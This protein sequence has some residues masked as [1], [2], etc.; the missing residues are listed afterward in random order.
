MNSLRF[1]N[2][3]FREVRLDDLPL[4]VEWLNDPAVQR[5]LSY[6]WP[7]TLETT[8]AWFER[9][10]GNNSREDFSIL[11]NDG[12]YIGF[13][14][15]LAIEKDVRRAEHYITIGDSRFR[16]RGYGRQTYILLQQF[17]FDVLDLNRL[18]GYQLT[19]NEAGHR[20]VE[21]LGWTREGLLRQDKLS[22]GKIVDRYVI[23]LLKEEWLT[24]KGGYV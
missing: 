17:A 12:E 22:H 14:G 19:N 15:V 23:S 20:L 8:K 1:G 9:R 2:V 5:T 7:V 11:T 6:E 3:H 10:L 13:C 24:L 21:K 4:R 18:Y 16:G